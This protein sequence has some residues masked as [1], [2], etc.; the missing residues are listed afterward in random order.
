MTLYQRVA[1]LTPNGVSHVQPIPSANGSFA[2]DLF[3]TPRTFN[4]NT[5]AGPGTYTL[6][7]QGLVAIMAYDATP[8]WAG[9]AYCDSGFGIITK[10]D[11]TM[12]V[13]PFMQAMAAICS[14]GVVDEPLNHA[15]RL[16]VAKTRPL[17]MRCGEV[18]NFVRG[19]A[20]GRGIE[21]RQVHLLNVTSP[22]YFDDGH[23]LL[24]AKVNGAW[25][26]FDVPNDCAWSDAD[27]D[28]L[29]LADVINLRPVN[30]TQVMLANPRVGRNGTGA[31]AWVP[32][33]YEMTYRTP[34]G[35]VDWSER[36]YE[37]PGMR[38]SS[39]IV[40][41]VPAHLSSYA[42]SIANYPGSSGWTTLPLDQ[43][44]LTYY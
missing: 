34:S 28:L 17:E 42:S 32:A 12:D 35:A 31:T 27:G 29:S 36:V 13:L 9:G 15:D 20:P 40:W 22:N 44:V 33:F 8:P 39:G 41:G 16:N 37:I 2:G 1:Y 26:V 38:T 7:Q 23:V 24:E 4:Y 43:W 21:T 30:A 10:P 19:C 18:T 3:K 14:Y 5:Y 25:K 6:S 11:G